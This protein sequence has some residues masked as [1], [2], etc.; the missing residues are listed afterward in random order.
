MLDYKKFY[1]LIGLAQKSGSIKSG[2]FLTQMAIS[3]NKAKLIIISE[4]AAPN[5]VDEIT[6]SCES[7]HIKFFIAGKMDEI[8]GCMGKSSRSVV[9][10]TN[11]GFGDA[12]LKLFET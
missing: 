11:K 3:K 10:I 9:A 7:N 6:K 5:T 8:G 12:L 2:I 4:D 1:S